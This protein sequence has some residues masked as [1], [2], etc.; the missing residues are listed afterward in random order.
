MYNVMPK[1][2]AGE[3]PTLHRYPKITYFQEKSWKQIFRRRA[4][5]NN[6]ATEIR[7]NIENDRVN[8]L[9]HICS[10]LIHFYATYF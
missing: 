9:M 1:V 2:V 5:R 7:L 10:L 3:M 4:K 8:T 6:A